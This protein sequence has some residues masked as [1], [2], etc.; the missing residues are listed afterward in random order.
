MF[1]LGRAEGLSLFELYCQYTRED[2][3]RRSGGC[4]VGRE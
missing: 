4:E 3:E 2:W 1:V